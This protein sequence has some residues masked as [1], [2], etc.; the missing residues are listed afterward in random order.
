MRCIR[1]NAEI[2]N[3]ATF[4]PNCGATQQSMIPQNM[5]TNTYMMANV[6]KSS[7]MFAINLIAIL[8]SIGA[9]FLPI[10]SYEGI[11]VNYVVNNGE[12]ADGVI[13][14]GLQVIAL[15]CLLCK[16][17]VPVLIFQ[18]LACGVFGVYLSKVIDAYSTYS[19]AVFELM[20]IGFWI[21]LGSLLIALITSIIRLA[22]KDKYV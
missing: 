7:S 22:G 21:L 18:L 17:K 19:S 3:N 15:I 2:M 6:N 11:S 12:V 8:A 13:V 5:M 14:I 20:G 16:K 10:I 4:C 1:C 9:C